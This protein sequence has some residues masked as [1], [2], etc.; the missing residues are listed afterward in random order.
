[1]PSTPPEKAL[2]NLDSAP[3][4]AHHGVA[5]FD[6]RSSDIFFAAVET[7][8]VPMIVT[9]PLQPD[10]PI[11]F[12]NRAFT[13]MTG[14]ARDDIVGSN[15]RFLQGTDTDPATVAQ[16]RDAI[17][18]GREIATE[19]LN[20]RKDGTP[21]WN[22]LFVSP[23]RDLNGDIVYYYASQLDISSRRD[24][25]DLLRQAQKMEALGQLTGSVA[26]D[27]NN[28][29]QVMT[30]YL[31]ILEVHAQADVVERPRVE[32]DV[33]SIR[34]AVQKAAI[35]TQ[36][37][38][39]FARKRRLD[40]TIVNL[41]LL[42]EDLSELLSGRIGENV[43]LRAE[44]A[45]DLWNCQIDP[46]RME[47]ALLNVLLNARDA[48]AQGGILTLST[49]NVVIGADRCGLPA[50]LAAGR[51]VT[52][53]ITDTGAGMSPALLERAMDPFFTTKADGK[54]TGLGLSMVH[55]FA[56]HSGGGVQMLSEVGHG[57]TIIMYFP[58]TD[59]PLQVP[60]SDEQ[61]TDDRDGTETILVVDDRIEVAELAQTM[62]EG[63]GYTVLVHSDP[64]EAL[65]CLGGARRVDMLF[66]DVVMPGGMN[67]VVLAREA[68]K[69][70][71]DLKILLTT[72]Y[73]DAA[74]ENQVLAGC[75][76][77]LIRK[78]YRRSELAQAV[79]QVLDA[80]VGTQTAPL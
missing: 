18:E 45:P 1:M 44:L 41:N 68:R 64:R 73:V 36:Q 7:T 13:R 22:A 50:G 62:L 26:H 80:S 15:C 24:T 16:V 65:D 69:R 51:Y 76:F 40:G 47:V 71:P 70:Q 56:K 54:G 75:E 34:S 28:L 27:F 5:A 42:T 66:S 72:G 23:V 25:E 58:A 14:Y 3:S 9:D 6:P 49:A 39:S 77:T 74:I 19:I 59:A 48:S 67:G 60:G 8:R 79:R 2:V 61:R 10:N 63:L 30:G 53:A 29:L 12:A 46:T 55:D 38:L 32:H 31:D 37:L 21:F 57:T 4:I 35:L 78:P 11:I 20:Y 33:Q 17:R 43:E 52:I